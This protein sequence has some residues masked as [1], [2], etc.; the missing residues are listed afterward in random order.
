MAGVKKLFA[1]ALMGAALLVELGCA[2]THHLGVKHLSV[3]E[4][5]TGL[6]RRNT[7]D[8]S[9]VGLKLWTTVSNPH[10]TAVRVI[11]RCEPFESKEITVPPN[12]DAQ[13]PLFLGFASKATATLGERW[14]CAALQTEPHHRALARWTQLNHIRLP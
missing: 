1:S 10:D 9:I 5:K 3:T 4:V 8:G 13:I 11:V 14:T 2:T 7:L 12:A 6:I